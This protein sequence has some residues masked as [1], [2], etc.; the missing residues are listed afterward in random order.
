[1]NQIERDK[2]LE[3]KILRKMKRALKFGSYSKAYKATETQ[4]S[5]N[6]DDKN[7]KLFKSKF[8]DNDKSYDN[9]K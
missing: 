2:K 7:Y 1:M 5:I 3:K 6:L 8:I 9:V 4:E